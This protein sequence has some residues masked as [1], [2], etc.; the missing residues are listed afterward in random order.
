MTINKAQGQSVVNV[1]LDLRTAVFG[2]G[3]LYVALSRCTSADRIKVLFPVDQDNTNTA[4]IVYPEV[5]IPTVYVISVT[6]T[7]V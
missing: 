4:N 1:G 6:T 5:L 3:Q 2:H 7:S